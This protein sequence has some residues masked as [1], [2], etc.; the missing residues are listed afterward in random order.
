MQPEF[1]PQL[2]EALSEDKKIIF[3]RAVSNKFSLKESVFILEFESWRILAYRWLNYIKE[4]QY[5]QMGL[6]LWRISG[7]FSEDYINYSLFS[8]VFNVFLKKIFSDTKNEIFT[9]FVI[10]VT[11]E[12]FTWCICFILT[13]SLN[14]ENGFP[15]RAI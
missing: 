7:S 4:L 2:A 3:S 10:F 1:L 6:D 9:G 13:C 5:W 12:Y 8:N 15:F 11:H 14:F